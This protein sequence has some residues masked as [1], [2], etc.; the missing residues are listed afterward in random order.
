M[1]EVTIH[2]AK[3][4]LSKLLVKVQS[5][6]EIIVRKGTQPVAKLVPYQK[7]TH[8]RPRTGEITSKRVKYSKNCFA[9]LTAEELKAWGM[10]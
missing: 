9:P 10:A 8:V 4:N 3:T 2:Q 7:R 6:R 1:I 5:G